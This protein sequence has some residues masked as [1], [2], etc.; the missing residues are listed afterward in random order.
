MTYNSNMFEAGR[1]SIYKS[2]PKSSS[3]ANKQ[4][5]GS[6]K[7]AGIGGIGG[8]PTTSSAK[9]IQD[10]FRRETQKDNDRKGLG[11]NPKVTPTPKKSFLESLYDRVR[12][13]ITFAGGDP[14]KK[15]RPTPNPGALY[16]ASPF[17]IPAA[18]AVTA[19]VLGPGVDYTDP[20]EVPRGMPSIYTPDSRDF[21][22]NI[23]TMPAAD[24]PASA[25]IDLSDLLNLKEKVVFRDAPG[26]MA[27][28]SMSKPSTPDMSDAI[29]RTLASIKASDPDVPY[30]IQAGDTLSEIAVQTGTTV[31]DLVKENKIEDKE[32]IYTGDELKIPS[33]KSTKTKKDIVSSLI[34][35]YEKKKDMSGTQT[36]SSGEILADATDPDAQF[37]QSGV[38]M[39]Q[40]LFAPEIGY[41][42]IAL[43]SEATVD[44]KIKGLGARPDVTVTELDPPSVKD[45]SNNLDALE[46]LKKERIAMAREAQKLLGITVDGDFG[47]GSKRSLASFQYKVG[48]PVSGKIDPDTMKALRDPNSADPRNAKPKM[49]VLNADGNAPDMTK[50]KEWAKE[51]IADPM[52]A[53]AFVSTVEAETGED[54][55]VETGYVGDAGKVRAIEVFVDRNA[56]KDG[57]LGPKMTARKAAIEAL[58]S[59]YSADDMFNVVYGNRLGNTE[60]SDGSTYKG[61]GLIQLTGKDNYKRVG[62]I[63]GVDLVANPDLVNDPKYAAPAAMAYLSLPNKNFFAK[64]I[65]QASLAATV[66][67]SDDKNKTVAAARFNRAKE[68]KEEMYP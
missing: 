45:Q 26:L 68:L 30:V 65:T 43:P 19:S 55:L 5:A 57:T 32:R 36:A 18:T 51:T 7:S 46:A 24:K 34:K 53:A 11:S 56:N 6:M 22:K 67:H 14:D 28:P 12:G 42:E 25:K 29:N 39:E 52:K 60:P 2:P 62:D 44:K 54:T 59:N 15:K 63:I 4:A 9:K 38:P 16:T 41:D 61:R 47:L 8:K 17:I 3:N 35:G 58:P 40:R 13:S 33:A 64:D 31:E 48:L 37:Y 49:E 27:S 66:G 10:Q 50:V 20:T 23:G 1:G 21:G